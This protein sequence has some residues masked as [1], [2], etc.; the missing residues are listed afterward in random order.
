MAYDDNT[1]KQDD[2]LGGLTAPSP[3]PTNDNNEQARKC[4]HRRQGD[5]LGGVF[6][7]DMHK[8]T[9]PL[10]LSVPLPGK[11]TVR[12]GVVEFEPDWFGRGC[13]IRYAFDVND[14]IL[15]LSA[16]FMNER[17]VLRRIRSILTT[18]MSR[19]LERQGDWIWAGHGVSASL[20]GGVEPHEPLRFSALYWEQDE[21]SVFPVLQP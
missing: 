17:A 1:Q 9:K 11:R 16:R 8:L 21:P 5:V 2:M 19:E 12:P 7:P 6:H 18:A 15:G 13:T 4:G 20:W 10:L 3:L 14:R